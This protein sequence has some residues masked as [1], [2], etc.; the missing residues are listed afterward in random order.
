MKCESLEVWQRSTTL[1]IEIYRYFDACADYS[2]K[3]QITRSALS[4]P[5]NIAEGLE[6]ISDKEKARFLEIAKA[7][8]SELATQIYIGI[9]ISRITPEVGEQWRLEVK[10][11]AAMLGGFIKWLNTQQGRKIGK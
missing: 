2:F 11:I 4:V 7:S 8:A 6:R 9:A 3:D 10:E 1:C 5:S